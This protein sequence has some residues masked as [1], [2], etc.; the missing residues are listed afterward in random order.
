MHKINAMDVNEAL[1]GGLAL[2]VTGQ[3]I[4]SPSR[5][6]EVRRLPMPVITHTTHPTRRVLFSPMRNANPFFHFME[7]LWMLAGRN[8]LPWLTHFN[9]RMAEFSDDGGKTQPGAYGLRWRRYWGYDQ[10]D[11]IVRMLRE[12]PS[13]RRAVLSM[14]DAHPAGDPHAARHG[15]ADVPCNTHVYFRIVKGR[16]DMTVC[17]RSNDLWW[18]AH[19]ANAVHFSVLQEY[20]AAACDVPVGSMYQLS[21]D[22]HLYTDVVKGDLIEL[23]QDCTMHNL[24]ITR[25][26]PTSLFL[27]SDDVRKFDEALPKFMDYA[28]P[29]INPLYRMADD[30][31][32]VRLQRDFESTGVS[33]ID[34][35]AHPMLRAWD[36][37]KHGKFQEAISWATNIGNDDNC[38]W[39]IAALQW[40]QRKRDRN[41]GRE[42]VL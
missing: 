2:C 30:K 5:N 25:A 11:G 6:G 17:C 42:K 24:Y 29:D 13:A 7:S 34:G 31:G 27:S 10:L 38:D 3:A 19:G 39:R 18:G 22:Y 23:V 1:A 26:Q 32:P 14:W 4:V 15:G 20:V 8:D 41:H 16:L 12:D 28:D 36:A 9:K 37:Q 21:N 35:I 40:L 33:A